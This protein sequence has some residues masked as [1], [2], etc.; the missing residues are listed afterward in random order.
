MF[1]QPAKRDIDSALSLLMHEARRRTLDEKNRITSDAINAGALTGNRLIVAVADEADKAHKAS[2]DTAK[3]ILIDFVERLQVPATEITRW[4]R[5]HLENLSNS[6]IGV[7]PSNGFPNDHK[8][9]VIQYSAI[10]QQRVDRAL[11]EVEI[12]YIRGVG[13]ARVEETGRT[14]RSALETSLTSREQRSVKTSKAKHSAVILT[15]LHVETRAVLRHLSDVREE[16]VRRTVFYVGQFG[17]WIVSVAECGEGNASAAA[18]VERGIARF[19]P[20]VALFVGVAG[21]VKDVQLGDALVSS[22][23]H[24]YERG[25]DTAE[26]F[27][28][29]PASPPSDYGL[30]QRARAIKHSDNWRKRLDPKQ[31]HKEPSLHV[32]PIAAGEKVVSSSSGAV[33]TYLRKYY[34]DTLGVE[35]EGQGFFAGVH[36]NNPVQGCVVRGISDLLDG[37]TEADKAGSQERAADV[38][39][40]VAFEM[41]ATLHAKAM[42]GPAR[43]RFFSSDQIGKT[44]ANPQYEGDMSRLDRLFDLGAVINRETVIIVI[45]KSIPVELLDRPVAELL[46]DEIDRRGGVE[47][48]FRRAIVITDAGWY[49]E[50]G[51]IASNAVIAIGG[52]RSNELTKE[53]EDKP[54]GGAVK[55]LISGR[56]GCNGRF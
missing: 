25:K 2:I 51:N 13:F 41:L 14:G 12:G 11:R 47:Y 5:P 6:V 21:G 10:F 1:E 34:G 50:A 54:A 17:D 22:R 55:F 28:P 53:F 29:R 8:H 43:F 9:A 3:T 7:I 30:D 42:D 20:E 39:S 32:G 49:A 31:T 44:M 23:V 4:A 19:T 38:A 46:R 45:G 26:G 37:K 18:I 40:A 27:A 15:A 52:P 36:I 16:I 48:P 24:S 33:A 56:E 35:M